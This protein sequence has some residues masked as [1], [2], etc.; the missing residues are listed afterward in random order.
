MGKLMFDGMM[1]RTFTTGLTTLK[2]LV[3]SEAIS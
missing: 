2:K 1:T 3:E